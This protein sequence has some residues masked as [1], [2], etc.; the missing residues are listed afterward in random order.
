MCASHIGALGYIYLFVFYYLYYRINRIIT[1]SDIVELTIYTLSPSS[2][3]KMDIMVTLSFNQ[4][5]YLTTY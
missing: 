3:F 1:L 4:K 2:P 5:A